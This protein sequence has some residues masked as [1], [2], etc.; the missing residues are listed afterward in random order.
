MILLNESVEGGRALKNVFLWV[1]A[2]SGLKVNVKKTKLYK[3]NEVS[4]WAEI[5][6]WKS[7]IGSFPDTYLGL[8]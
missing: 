7:A 1:E 8:L 3:A 6:E 5:C 4:G 2:F